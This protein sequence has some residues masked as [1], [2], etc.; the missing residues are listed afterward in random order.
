MSVKTT[1]DIVLIADAIDREQ[2]RSYRRAQMG[3][4]KKM[5]LVVN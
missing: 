5:P 4:A 1:R 3:L 2:A